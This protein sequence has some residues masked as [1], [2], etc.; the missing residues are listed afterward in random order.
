MLQLRVDLPE[1]FEASG[2]LTISGRETM[3][4]LQALLARFGMENFQVVR[5]DKD[6]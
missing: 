4:V 2:D 5:L 6:S 3:L 1:E